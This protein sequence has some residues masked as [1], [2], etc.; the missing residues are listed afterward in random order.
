MLFLYFFI[1]V[2]WVLGDMNELN[3]G[4]LGSFLIIVILVWLLIVDNFVFWKVILVWIMEV[5]LFLRDL[6]VFIGGWGFV[7]GVLDIMD[8][9]WWL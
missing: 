9:C 8:K 3:L 1:I 7:G 6:K 4:F 5:I 2:N